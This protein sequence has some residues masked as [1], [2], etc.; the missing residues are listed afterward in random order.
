MSDLLTNPLVLPLLCVCF[1]VLQ[2]I[3]E[4]NC[5]H[6]AAA[7]G[8]FLVTFG[9]HFFIKDTGPIQSQDLLN[10]FP[11]KY[12]I[13]LCVLQKLTRQ[14][15]K[16]NLMEVAC[17]YEGK[18]DKEL[19]RTIL[20]IL[21]YTV[22]WSFVTFAFIHMRAS[23]II[24]SIPYSQTKATKSCQGELGSMYWCFT[25]CAAVNGSFSLQTCCTSIFCIACPTSFPFL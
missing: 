13:C 7:L 24:S 1:C 2:I 19:C 21:Q 16:G 3:L 6:W 25:S 10:E 17:V 20:C 12:F 22:C 9:K 15:M 14:T 18:C 8:A 23:S 11:L 5:S 4:L